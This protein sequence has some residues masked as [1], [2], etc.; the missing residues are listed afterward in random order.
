MA[1]IQATYM[2]PER[3]SGLAHTVSSDIWSLGLSMMEAATG[4][5]DIVGGLSGSDLIGR[6]H[7]GGARHGDRL[8]VGTGPKWEWA[9]SGK[10][11]RG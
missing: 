1:C 9:L 4:R 2:S 8:I 11:T 5:C 10:D 6:P 7:A 3:I